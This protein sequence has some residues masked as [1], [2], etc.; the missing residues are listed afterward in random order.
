M[1]R[2]AFRQRNPMIDRRLGRDYPSEIS[3]PM[4]GGAHVYQSPLHSLRRHHGLQ[5]PAAASPSAAPSTAPTA[6]PATKDG[7]G[8]QWEQTL[9]AARKEG[10]VTVVTH[11]ICYRET[12]QK[13]QEKYPDIS[14]EHV[15]IRPSEF[16]PKVVTEQ[17]NGTFGYDLW[18]SSTSNMVEVVLPA[19]G[20]DKL[21]PLLILPE[22]TEG[23]EL[24]T[25]SLSWATNEPF[26][27][28]Q[29]RK[30]GRQRLGQSRYLTGGRIQQR[31]AGS[32]SKVQGQND[33]PHAQFP[34]GIDAYNDGLASQQG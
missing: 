13:F 27:L 31:G 6:V 30:R 9:Q 8:A 15:A 11:T 2:C 14:V 24:A 26:I 10:S 34:A 17:Q 28:A 23:K 22:V 33:D 16:A 7:A 32:G 19:G 12:V 1:G 21:T 18:V 20:F 5:R 3:L 4:A 29:S 25:G